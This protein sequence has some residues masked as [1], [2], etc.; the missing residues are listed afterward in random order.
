MSTDPDVEAPTSGLFPGDTGQ[1]PHDTRRVIVRLL[2]G[3]FL[4]PNKHS[5]LWPTLIRDEAIVRQRLHELFLDLVMDAN[6][7]V[8]FIRQVDTSYDD[9]NPLLLRT[10]PLT[11][12]DSAFM[13]YLRQQLTLAS[14]RDQR[15]VI[16]REEALD[17]LRGYERAA[18]VDKAKFTRQINSAFDKAKEQRLLNPLKGSEDRFEISPTLKLVFDADTIA[19]LTETYERMREASAQGTDVEAEREADDAEE[20]P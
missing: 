8:A 5:K 18:N 7:Q 15:A 19:T 10:L 11:L 6:Q 14:A 1:L 20:A 17:H 12:V 16:S 2:L 13:L 9:D 4:D 3:P